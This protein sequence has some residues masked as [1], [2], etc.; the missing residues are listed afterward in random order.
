L[1]YVEDKAAATPEMLR[2]LRPD[3]RVSMFDPINDAPEVY[4]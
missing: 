3:G 2:V 1:I 4:G